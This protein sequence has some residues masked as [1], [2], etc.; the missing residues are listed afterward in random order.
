MFIINRLFARYYRDQRDRLIED[1]KK[2]MEL[3]QMENK[4]EIMKLRNDRLKNELES[5]NRELATTA[6]SLINKNELL[7]WDKWRDGK[8]FN[9]NT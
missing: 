7:N 1:N 8:L 6:M 4:Q 3:S 9:W 5:K 2:K